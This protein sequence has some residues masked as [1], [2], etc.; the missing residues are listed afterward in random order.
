MVG[1]I[2]EGTVSTMYYSN[3]SIKSYRGEWTQV[4]DFSK[5]VITEI[6]ITTGGSSFP[7]NIR[8]FG[9]R[10]D[11][12][13]WNSIY[14]FKGLIPSDFTGNKAII[15]LPVEII[16]KQKGEWDSV[17]FVVNKIQ[18]ST[19]GYLNITSLELYG[20]QNFIPE[21]QV[22]TEI[23]NTDKF[24]VLNTLKSKLAIDDFSFINELSYF[25]PKMRVG[26]V[27]KGY[28]EGGYKLS[29]REGY[30]E[31]EFNT[32]RNIKWKTDR[33]SYLVGNEAGV[34][35]DNYDYDKWNTD[36]YKN[37]CLSRP[38]CAGFIYEPDAA[39]P[40]VYY[41][42]K[43]GIVN[44]DTNTYIGKQLL[45]VDPVVKYKRHDKPDKYHYENIVN[46]AN[47][48]Y[49]T[50]DINIFMSPL[51]DLDG[52][53]NDVRDSV[54][55]GADIDINY[56]NSDDLTDWAK[57]NQGDQL[58]IY[59]INNTFVGKINISSIATAESGNLASNYIY[60]DYSG[61]GNAAII[62][63]HSNINM[64]WMFSPYWLKRTLEWGGYDWPSDWAVVG[65]ANNPGN[66]VHIYSHKIN[67]GVGTTALVAKTSAEDS[68]G[69]SFLIKRPDDNMLLNGNVA[70]GFGGGNSLGAYEPIPSYTMAAL[71]QQKQHNIYDVPLEN[72]SYSNVDQRRNTFVYRQS[73]QFNGAIA[74]LLTKILGTTWPA[75]GNAANALS[76]TNDKNFLNVL[77]QWDNAEPTLFQ[78]LLNDFPYVGNHWN[79]NDH[80]R[81]YSVYMRAKADVDFFIHHANY[82]NFNN[83]GIQYHC[84]VV[85]DLSNYNYSSVAFHSSRTHL[86]NGQ[87]NG[88]NWY[89]S[90]NDAI[91][92]KSGRL[93][94][95]Y[96]ITYYANYHYYA[97][98][99]YQFTWQTSPQATPD[100][101][102]TVGT[103]K[104]YGSSQTTTVNGIS[105]WYATMRP[106]DK[107]E[108]FGYPPSN[109]RLDS[110]S[111][112][113]SK[114]KEPL[115]EL[116]IYNGS[117]SSGSATLVA[118]IPVKM[119]ATS[120]DTYM[121]YDGET[122]NGMV[123]IKN[124]TETMN[125][126]SSQEIYVNH[127]KIAVEHEGGTWPT[128]WQHPSAWQNY[129][130]FDILTGN[131]N[132]FIGN[133]NPQ[134]S[135]W[136]YEYIPPLGNFQWVQLDTRCPVR[137]NGIKILPDAIISFNYAKKIKIKVSTNGLDWDQQKEIQMD[138]NLDYAT[139]DGTTGN[140]A[141]KFF[142]YEKFVRYVRVYIIEFNGEPSIRVGLLTNKHSKILKNQYND[143]PDMEYNIRLSSQN[144]N[145]TSN[146]TFTK[147]R[148]LYWNGK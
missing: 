7:K 141:Y 121:Q 113:T 43:E 122:H 29:I 42:S 132:N 20:Y 68:I 145:G 69:W 77:E 78:P 32:E 147:C 46:T 26:S 10:D 64:R 35:F 99:G 96:I 59:D 18:A 16:N 27:L 95:L 101:T 83:S 3:N 2:Y 100:P 129:T 49:D 118:T 125:L 138:T 106:N 87:N 79:N 85:S 24:I 105:T 19:N 54:F 134:R 21:W 63:F 51:K 44:D 110:T 93:Y 25:W 28:T 84:A 91:P 116:K 124:H 92:L 33:T 23:I 30:I 71:N 15:E 139:Y 89:H 133:V 114:A 81:V 75:G 109:S 58:F 148:W 62:R 88:S 50:T 70:Q 140:N 74:G 47:T 135:V 98:A 127:V 117:E 1:G 136:Y 48:K 115:G 52:G 17:R 60:A 45:E 12:T 107:I 108:W 34:V 53:L 57:I 80:T 9:K 130:T 6:H 119:V 97:G 37:E 31:D 142:K 126:H 73:S 143:V 56:D 128:N 4:N 72:H 36:F 131:I 39:D 67:T 146:N 41:V 55:S 38:L 103:G 144:T 86:G 61:S 82:T 11:S 120:G 5:N 14:E 90:A 137:I 111:S 66:W 102:E 123:L 22:D 13:V 8:L 76:F 94:K 65:T 40:K 112:W 104:N